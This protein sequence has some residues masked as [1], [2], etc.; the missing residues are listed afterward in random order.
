MIGVWGCCC[1]LTD[2]YLKDNEF[3]IHIGSL[4]KGHILHNSGIL[5]FDLMKSSNEPMF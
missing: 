1:R 4:G 2:L 3:E 5:A